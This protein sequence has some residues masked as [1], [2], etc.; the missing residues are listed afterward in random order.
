MAF[1]LINEANKQDISTPVLR[2]LYM[3][4]GRELQTVSV[5]R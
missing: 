4:P 1:H 2:Y 5:G 3:G